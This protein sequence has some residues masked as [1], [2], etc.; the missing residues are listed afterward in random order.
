MI[1]HCSIFV[2]VTK[3]HNRFG[4][5]SHF[6]P[7]FSNLESSHCCISAL[8]SPWSEIIH[9][10]V[11]YTAAGSMTWRNGNICRSQRVA[12]HDRVAPNV[13]FSLEPIPERED[14]LA[15]STYNMLYI[16]MLPPPPEPMFQ[17]LRP[18]LKAYCHVA[19]IW[20][21][22]TAGAVDL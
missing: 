2:L 22:K 18:C 14:V 12:T 19:M 11:Q 13:F 20:A 3:K 8:V 17:K 10:A 16:Y 15:V 4:D 21:K 6:Q 9:G 5:I 1:H 7:N